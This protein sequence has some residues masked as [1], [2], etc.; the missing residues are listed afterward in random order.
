MRKKFFAMYAL[1]GA[2][3]ASPV[4]TSCVDDSESASV[5]ALRGAKAEQLSALATLQKAQ[6]EA[7]KVTAD[8][9]KAYKE[10]W[11][12]YYKAQANSSNASA[13]KILQEMEQAKAKFEY[14]IAYI[15]ADYEKKIA[16][17]KKAALKAEQDILENA[18]TRLATLYI[19]YSSA[20]N[21]LNDLKYQ[22]AEK[23]MLLTE[24]E[25]GAVALDEVIL[26]KK[27]DLEAQIAEAEAQIKAWETYQ[28]IDDADLDAELL[29]AQQAK[30][31][32][33]AAKDAAD[34]AVIEPKEAAEEVLD[35][36]DLD[37]LEEPSTVAAVAAIQA[38]LKVNPI[39]DYISLGWFNDKDEAVEYYWEQVKNSNIEYVPGDVDKIY[40]LYGNNNDYGRY[41]IAG[42]MQLN[43]I[44]YQPFKTESVEIT[45]EKSVPLYSLNKNI[46][47]T[48]IS[49]AFVAQ[50]ENYTKNLGAAA[51]E[52]TEAT[53]YY[54]N[55]A[56]AEKE[57]KDYQKDLADAKEALTAGEA[58]VK[59]AQAKVDEA[60]AAV[61]AEQA[62]IDAEQDKIDAAEAVIA[63]AN[64]NKSY[65]QTEKSTYEELKAQAEA[66]KTTAEA[67][68]AAA[69]T[70]EAK[71][72]ADAD[73]A[74]A[75]AA[76]ADATAKIEAYTDK[77][78]AAEEAIE[79]ADETIEAE[80]AKIAAANK[81]IADI[82]IALNEATRKLD[83]V[84]TMEL[85]P[86][87]A[88]VIAAK[89]DIT[90]AESDIK[91]G[92]QSVARWKDNIEDA[93]EFL[94][95]ADEILA[96][97]EAVV[98]ELSGDKFTAYEKEVKELV[99]NETV[100]A[101]LT[102]VEAAAEANKAYTDAATLVTTLS[103]AIAND[104]VKNAA[105]EIATLKETI[106]ELKLDIAELET[107]RMPIS[108]EYPYTD[109]ATAAYLDKA[110]EEL[111]ADIAS[112]EEEIAIQEE[113]VAFRK[114]AL[115][116][117]LANEE[118]TPAE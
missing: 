62:K 35:Q 98:A 61:D 13:D 1:A 44:Y 36:Y 97:W 82:Q 51:T 31:A 14:E 65:A 12:E 69:T 72:A 94:A 33:W 75:T 39:D 76:I 101:W 112:L 5:T 117:F 52:T 70:D 22:K 100:A 15:K 96:A 54:K 66:N 63:T 99:A 6:A 3:V 57:L 28:G 105:E 109:N 34:E 37:E 102:L 107:T 91:N 19:N 32:A 77:I 67:N 81:V 73:I 78:E 56:D 84:Q 38:F 103:S 45:D 30:Y 114:A 24:Y 110:I 104:N 89:N 55:L 27:N 71:A 74:A 41:A 87:E 64:S 49:Q 17:A 88:K 25:A 50:K 60:Q 92:E 4:F 68:K 106:A 29:A 115:D 113:V 118:E 80:Q 85:T 111:K 18:E 10:A 59:A 53:G 108:T 40:N 79:T 95:N 47:T 7:A 46:S 86:A 11:A 42:Y 9:E 20:V 58:E 21:T 93:I 8:A 26:Q 2:L 23:E 48:Q 83:Q 116:E 43:G 16:E 90:Q